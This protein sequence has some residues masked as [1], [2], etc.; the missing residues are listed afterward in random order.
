MDTILY[1]IALY[2]IVSLLRIGE[3]K[4]GRGGEGRLISLSL[5]V[6]A[7]WNSRCHFQQ[8]SMPFVIHIYSKKNADGT[9]S[10]CWCSR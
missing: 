10:S 3:G 5:I 2:C 7:I 1:C 8:Q 6:V 4:G 9:E